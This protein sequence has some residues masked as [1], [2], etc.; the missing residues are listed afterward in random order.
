MITR[1]MRRRHRLLGA[2][3]RVELEE[4]GVLSDDRSVRSQ[5]QPSHP[6][7]EAAEQ[8]ADDGE[9]TREDRPA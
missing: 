3:V 2:Y 4:R 6:W 8:D 5:P 9:G 1:R 7:P